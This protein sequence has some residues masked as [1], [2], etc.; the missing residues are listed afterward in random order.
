MQNYFVFDINKCV[1]C[2]ACVVACTIENGPQNPTP[3]RNIHTSNEAHVPGLPLFHFSLACNHC[4]QAPCMKSCPANAFSRDEVTGAVIHH[5]EKCIGC[6]YCTWACPFDAPKYNPI[7]GVIEKCTFCAHR[8]QENQK[9]ACAQLCPT[10]AL[11]FSF[12][13]LSVDKSAQSSPV[14][15]NVGSRIHTQA[16]RD[17]RGPQQDSTLFFSPS[18]NKSKKKPLRKINALHEWPLIVFTLLVT[19]LVSIKS[20]FI[21][22]PD[23]GDYYLFVLLLFAAL[24]STLHLGKKQR[25]WRALLNVKSSWLS[26]EI[27]LFTLFGL[28]MLFQL[29]ITTVPLWLFALLG[30]VL[31]FAIDRLYDVATWQW[32]TKLHS[33]QTLWMGLSAITFLNGWIYL[34]GLVALLRLTL[35][36]W[37]QFILPENKNWFLFIGTLMLLITVVGMLLRLPFFVLLIV[38]L[39]GEIMQRIGF[40]QALQVASPQNDLEMS[41]IAN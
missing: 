41:G 30:L 11:D 20:S 21:R 5:P 18:F 8:V 14:K 40:Y 13:D 35:I 26:R 12:A 1:G 33:A 38:F 27:A 16:L 22:L 36:F 3:W 15:V 2:E 25:A 19:A 6:K 7:S 10:G 9:P 28:L 39:A 29:F 32:P 17:A 4:E 23:A 24:M 31:L 34:F 37:H